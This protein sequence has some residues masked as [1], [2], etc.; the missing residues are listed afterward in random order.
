MSY[1]KTLES[2]I[3]TDSATEGIGEKI[4]S[5]L[6]ALVSKVKELLKKFKDWFMGIF[7]KNSIEA[8]MRSFSI[9]LK[10]FSTDGQTVFIKNGE[11]GLAAIHN[12]VF[13]NKADLA[14]LSGTSALKLGSDL[15]DAINS[16]V[17]IMSNPE[18]YDHGLFG[19][20]EYQQKAVIGDPGE[21]IKEELPQIQEVINHGYANLTD[22]AIKQRL[23]FGLFGDYKKVKISEVEEKISKTISESKKVYQDIKAASTRILSAI[24]KMNQ[25]M[26]RLESELSRNADL[27]DS[28]RDVIIKNV[29]SVVTFTNQTCNFNVLSYKAFDATYVNAAKKYTHYVLQ[30][31]RKT[32]TEDN[33]G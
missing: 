10:E 2:Y 16:Y 8:I 6:K 32:A 12:A 1:I 28:Q 25:A 7:R 29:S 5:G 27:S 26:S 3:I 11:W 4:K 14:D 21:R 24:E 31:T 13:P 30:Y 19:N 33:K 23:D 15:A 20:G 22:E 17:K 9:K 18:M